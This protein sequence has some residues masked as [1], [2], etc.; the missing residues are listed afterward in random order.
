MDDE[1]INILYQNG[2]FSSINIRFAKFITEISGK[3]DPVVFLSAALVSRSTENQDVCLDLSSMAG[4]ALV[5]NHDQKGRKEYT[6]RCPELDIWQKK[7]SASSVVGKPGV[8]CP[9]VLDDKYRLYLYRYW[10]YEKKLSDSIKKRAACNVNDINTSLLKAG[11]KRL[12]PEKDG[13]ETDRQKLSAIVAVLKR[14]SVISGGPGTGKTTT[15]AKILALLLEQSKA[16]GPRIF[17]S[18]PTGKAA[19]RLMES[20]DK[21]KKEINCAD[22]I[23]ALIPD[24]AYTIHRIL[25]SIAGSPYFRHNEEN[26]LGADVVVVDEASMVDIA[27]M[28]KLVQAVPADAR[29]ILLGD[30]DQLASVEAGSVLG[31]I[32]NRDNNHGFS[33]DFSN[34]IEALTGRKISSALKQY[35]KSRGICNSI[36]ILNKSYRFKDGSMIDGF[37]RAVNRQDADSAINQLKSEQDKSINWDSNLFPD[38][39]YEIIKKSVIKGY[40]G[41]LKTD[42]VA[43]ALERFNGFRILC[44]LRKGPFGVGAVNRIAEHVLLQ[45]NLLQPDK[46][47]YK[48]RPILITKNDYNLQLFNGD[49]G[50]I[51][52]DSGMISDSKPNSPDNELYAFFPGA[53]GAVRRFFLHQLPEHETVFAMTVHKSQG[54]EFDNV[55]LILPNKDYPLL[56]KEL[57]YTGV[58]RARQNVSICAAE[59]V[60]RTSIARVIKRTSGL[61]DALWEE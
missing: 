61:R 42:D 59:S 47:W 21:A 46:T 28:S 31:D 8:F 29:L 10:E 50:I 3:N 38:D 15:I 39:L 36:I 49:T 12:F 52:P 33:E 45:K 51:M 56:T 24:K 9:L 13:H 14:F 57:I 41:Y 58:T 32:C 1:S 19:A 16:V 25:K 43:Q 18:A 22:N 30:K 11:L 55:L 35:N 26:P 5:E 20:I 4:K 2:Y 60:L 17:L 37:S 40:T 53:S 23:K 7:L 48:G 6:A 54:S 27:L 44:A 34:K